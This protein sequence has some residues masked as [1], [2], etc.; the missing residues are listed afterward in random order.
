[1]E[2]GYKREL[3][4]G[5]NPVSQMERVRPNGARERFFTPQE[6]HKLLDWL[7]NEDLPTYHLTLCAAHT[8]AR[9]G[10]LAQL[11]WD[12]VNIDLEQIDFIHTKTNRPRSVPMTAELRRMFEAMGQGEAGSLVFLKKNK[13]PWF[14]YKD[15]RM[16]TDT[17][18]VF[19]RALAA[20]QLNVG[21]KANRTKLTFHCL[22]HTAATMLLANG[23]DPVTVQSILGWSTLRMLERYA[24]AI[25]ATKRQA[26]SQLERS[27]SGQQAQTI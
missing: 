24:H 4:E 6:L 8:G 1:M 13:S 5:R 26:I 23:V 3:I 27:L 11:T 16:R 18:P 9:L 25:P 7:Q 10:E 12:R 21:H 20:L 22:R 2:W 15:G 14:T 19:R 17:P